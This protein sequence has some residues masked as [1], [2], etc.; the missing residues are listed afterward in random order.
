MV[1]LFQFSLKE[2]VRDKKKFVQMLSGISDEADTNVNATSKACLV[3]LWTLFSFKHIFA[4][5]TLFYFA[6]GEIRKSL[7]PVLSGRGGEADT[8]VSP[9]ERCQVG[10]AGFLF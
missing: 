1:T 9:G 10:A 8:N 6:F 3:N 4:V 7:S 5:V 2:N